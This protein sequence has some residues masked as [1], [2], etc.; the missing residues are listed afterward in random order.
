MIY[1]YVLSVYSSVHLI[2]DFF[3]VWWSRSF[4]L[5]YRRWSTRTNNQDGFFQWRG[6]VCFLQSSSRIS[7]GL[8]LRLDRDSQWQPQ[9]RVRFDSRGKWHPKAQLGRNWRQRIRLFQ[10]AAWFP[11]DPEPSRSIGQNQAH[12]YIQPQCTS[13]LQRCWYST[14]SRATCWNK[15]NISPMPLNW[16]TRMARDLFR[17][18]SMDIRHT[19]KCRWK[20]PSRKPNQRFLWN[21]Y[22]RFLSIIIIRSTNKSY[23]IVEIVGA[24]SLLTFVN[25]SSTYR[26]K[27]WR[28]ILAVWIN[29]ISTKEPEI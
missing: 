4:W 3:K 5:S 23:W 29:G 10:W 26:I 8:H 9:P 19:F 22:V 14:Y 11:K 24:L 7:E 25:Y 13:S 27:V 16:F 12:Q 15:A 1:L 2:Y 20:C 28:S 17:Q 6:L 21:R 18:K